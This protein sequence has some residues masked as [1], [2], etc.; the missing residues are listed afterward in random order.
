[1]ARLSWAYGESGGTVVRRLGGVGTSAE[2]TEAPVRP[3]AEA[4]YPMRNACRATSL[5]TRNVLLTAACR[6]SAAACADAG[7][8]RGGM[9]SAAMSRGEPA[10][11]RHTAA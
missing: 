10:G 1:M 5:V 6:T 3:F 8:S 4:A 7:V 2:A 11:R 9:P